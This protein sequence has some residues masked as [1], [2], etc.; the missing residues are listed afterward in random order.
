MKYEIM[1]AEEIYLAPEYTNESDDVVSSDIS[2]DNSGMMKSITDK[3][4][5]LRKI[6]EI[7]EQRGNN[8]KV[9]RMSD[10]TESA[11][12]S[13][14]DIHVFDDETNTFEE[15]DNTIIEDKDGR[16]F[17]CG[18]N[19]F[20][21]KFSCE[22]D[23]DD[24][25]SI[26]KGIH[27]ITVYA[28]KN[29]KNKNR[30]IKPKLHQ[31]HKE[32][33]RATNALTFSDIEQDTDYE[34]FVEN[35]GV[36]ENIIVKKPADIY[37]YP[38]MLK[39]ENVTARFDESTKQIAF[40]SNET[41]DEVF[42]IPAPFM[43]D[44][45]GV[46]S[47]AV[48]FEVSPSDNGIVLLTVTAD[49]DWINYPERAFPVAIDPQIKLSGS[50]SMSTYSWNNGSLISSSLHTIGT[51]DSGVSS[52][53]T[54]SNASRMYMSF[55]MP[56]LPH[57]PRIKKAELQVSQLSSLIKYHTAPLFGLYQVTG[58][59]HTGTYT[60]TDDFNLIDYARMR[61]G[62]TDNNEVI[63]Y[64][65][66][67]T[68]LVDKID[69]NES[70]SPQLVLKMLDES[71]TTQNCITLYGSSYGGDYTPKI[72]ITYESSYGVNTSYRTHSHE[73]GRFGQG[74]VDLQCG[75]LM[76]ESE[77]FSWSGNRMPVTIK[78][79]YNSAL[80]GYAY[81]NN[82]AIKLT[83][84]EFSA[85]KL[86]CGFK[87]NIMQSMVASSFVHDGI[88]YSG[89]VYIGENGEE[90]YFRK[91]ETQVSCGSNTQ[92]YNIYKDINGEDMLYDPVKL[93]LK[94]GEDT[95]L[96]DSSGRLIKITDA[97]G[98]HMDISYTSG[99]ITSVTDGAGREFGFTYN[100]GGHLTCIIAPDLT[101]INY[102]YTDSLLTG[103]SY[104]DGK[105]AVIT[106]SSDKPVS[107]TLKDTDG[108][109][110]YRVE[111]SFGGN[112]LHSVTEYGSDNTIGAKSTYSYSVASGRT[113]VTTT[114]QKDTDEGE[115]TDNIITTTYTFDDDGNVISEYVYSKDTGN[116]GGN[117]EESGINPHSGDGGAGVVSN[118]NNLL[119][120]HNFESL[121]SWLEMPNNSNDFSIGN[122]ENETYAVFGR[123]ILRLQSYNTFCS[124]N[125]VYQLTNSLP[126]GQYTFSAYLRVLSSEFRG[127][128]SGAFLR[129]TDTSGNVL[130]IS[131]R[132]NR[133]D[134]EYTRLILPFSLDSAQ[135]VQ[136]Q[137]VVNGSGTVYVDAAQL[138]NNPY[139]NAYNM[140]ENGNFERGTAG[141]YCSADGVYSTSDTRF[142]MSKSLCM[143]TSVSTE[144][145]AYQVPAV[146]TSRSTRETF[147]L[148]GWAKGYGLPNH[149]RKD[150]D[151]TPRFRLRAVVKYND[152]TYNEYGTEEF[153]ADFSPCTEEWQFAS[154]R[155]S[156][157]KYRTIQNIRIYCEYGYNF[158]SVYFDD[159]QL[160]RNSLETGLS[161]SDFVVE[162]TGASDDTADKAA[163][164]TPTFSEAKDTFGN[165][166]TE[167]T[168]TDG[169]FGTIYRS[170]RFNEDD[171]S[172]AGNDAGNN[173]VEETDARGNTTSYTVDGDTSRN[174]EVTDRLGNRTA[175]EYDASGRTT[176][177]TSK[178]ADGG[179]LANVSYS[180]DTFDN[181]TEIV[182][183]DGMKYALAYNGFHNLESIGIDGK[184][185]KL[186]RYTYKNGNG[187]LKQ[188]TYA[189]GH[190]M[191]A[192]YNSIGQMVAERWFETEAAVSD[193][194]AIPIANYKY[195]Y[196]GEG[197]IVRSVDIVGKKEYNY[198]Y[199]EGRIVRSTEADITLSG[200][201]ITSKVVV[202]TIKY[203]YDFEGNLISKLCIY[204]NGAV[205]SYS[206]EIN[207][208][209]DE[210]V[211]FKIGSS[212]VTSH[213]KTDKFLRKVF[214]ELETG[215]TFVS[216]QFSYLA[217]AVTNRHQTSEKLKST[218]TTQLVSQII[219]SN[220]RIISYKY[221][222]EDRIIH[223]DDSVSGVFDYTYNE[224][225]QLESE[226]INGEKTKF[227][228]DAYGNIFEK[229][230]V[231]ETGSIVEATKISYVYGNNT[232]KDL[233][234]SYNGQTITYDAQ[235][236]P[237]SY[238]GHTLIWE[239]GRQLKSI[240]NTVYTY[241]AN[242]VRVSKNVNGVLHTFFVEGTK[243]VCEKW[244][245]N[246]L[247]PLYD[248]EDIVCG[249][250]Y[251]NIPYYF[252]RNLQ[253][254]II[255][256]VD[257]EGNTVA[258]YT[259]DAWGACIS[260]TG[261]SEITSI[262][263]FR[264][265][266]YYC[267]IET[268]YYY[269]QT[270]YYDPA[271]GRFLNSDD[272][273]YLG[274]T[275]CPVGFNLF[276]YC[277]NNPINRS[278]V[279]GHSWI[280]DRFNDVKNAA[281]KIAKAVSNTAQKVAST[282][283]TVTT[284]VKNAVVNTAKK[285]AATVTNATKSLVTTVSGTAKD[286]VDWTKNKIQDITKGVKN[287]AT[288][289][290]EAVVEAWNW[291]T[292]K[293][294]HTV[295]NFFS[296]T[297]WKK[298]IVGGVWETFCK[299]W[300][301][302]TFCK[303]WVWETFCKDWVW[304]T[305]C[306]K[307]VWQTVLVGAWKKSNTWLM[308]TISKLIV[309]QEKLTITTTSIEQSNKNLKHN[310]SICMQKTWAQ[311]KGL[312]FNQGYMP[313]YEKS[314]ST[315]PNVNDEAILLKCCNNRDLADV[316]CGLVAVYNIGVL[317]NTHMDMRSIIY[318]F[319]QNDGFVLNGVF[320]LNPYAI[321]SFYDN[322]M[323]PY[324]LYTDLSELENA[325]AQNGKYIVCQWNDIT[326]ITKGAHFYAIEERNGQLIPY[327]AAY[328]YSALANN[329]NLYRY[330]NFASVISY[331]TDR[332]GGLIC[333]YKIG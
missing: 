293:A 190:T 240:D 331:R 168:F 93:T 314:P 209:E 184:T 12:F 112:R 120:G 51:A 116:V 80:A 247:V 164:T 117:G 143:N 155:F 83:T 274:T 166:L 278:D 230:A 57:N 202:Y 153:T 97:S 101:K 141:W 255:A 134:S 2:E 106:Y 200:D 266:G 276:S 146:R 330:N 113:L 142:N 71:I 194:T 210:V 16:H 235:G 30:G 243:I 52:C 300:V 29:K 95:Y 227:V 223:I 288:K 115:T 207:E 307:W 289:A 22:E 109:Q 198:E 86:G 301:W 258:H 180:Y 65:F 322:I 169:E 299:D 297:V 145:Y 257:K 154:V 256:I 232:W 189:N 104:P 50:T 10:G 156:K 157:S 42:F 74:S 158:G 205:T 170:F 159:I 277:D 177:V 23:N 286:A 165:A 213:S 91:S 56:S 204:K 100:T 316:G 24:I 128:D 312:I 19:R 149:D 319:E 21:A 251:N 6:E 217:G 105:N 248:N 28:R 20:I 38:F 271:T 206:Y 321:K 250:V 245:G 34:Y 291:T 9:F 114:E 31:N 11:V 253:D 7:P 221:D 211:K 63:S 75:N 273:K 231:D 18:K 241:N 324:T 215:T 320:G 214:D 144:K 87:L 261:E 225:N 150:V 108:N 263:P 46:V 269:L 306:K 39:C 309:N 272:I 188:M 58:G 326:N 229:G 66:D 333:A 233:L 292:K 98:N 25:F 126:K 148:S 140:L 129:V 82:N 310:T 175:Y 152:S 172:M 296:E 224:L 94:H 139:A 178:R 77:D 244:E 308:N 195:V 72:I 161:A 218:A 304:E 275:D 311:S 284:T 90:T 27:K 290:K 47:T 160:V 5:K 1:G 54:C 13:P 219:F 325:K 111:Y 122:Y 282:V 317:L 237:T 59:I 99:R 127:T 132:L 197:N 242:D 151:E 79:L 234:T 73:L 84:A 199:E 68:S 136:I 186:I 267:D 138:E 37:R 313:D 48:S 40:I 315:Y 212:T 125:G 191:K 14:S 69:K 226:T 41:G 110:V 36:K 181:M 4:K 268:G 124:N 332:T 270:R 173:L 64:T 323:V 60:P 303:D 76:F 81:T 279:N 26:E 254:D 216:R 8:V 176:K 283:K 260:A 163:D 281:K 220:G 96:F 33:V 327:N 92:C 201:V 62:Y 239:K 35:G 162:S 174:E 121:T 249:I 265:R 45:N 262:N 246:V 118:I 259:Y 70:Y 328:N 318:W 196:D 192:T 236:N 61:K 329:G 55:T 17:T 43:T 137:I 131:E 147:T 264:Y 135:S 123:K 130:G 228:Y 222:A 3:L 171:N 107:V 185:E 88:S 187:R 49:A 295:G 298:W 119:S 280:S 183:G 167:T 15:I 285:A 238:L 53:T 78:H 102:T 89:Y 85:M 67:I 133:Y 203:K 193:P 302:E 294:L 179:E 32:G 182:R 103:I 252:H 208:T 305:F 287:I 44:A